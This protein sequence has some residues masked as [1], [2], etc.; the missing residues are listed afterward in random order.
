MRIDGSIHTRIYLLGMFN[1]HPESPLTLLPQNP[2]AVLSFDTVAVWLG[3]QTQLLSFLFG[4][5]FRQ[6]RTS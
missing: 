2:A 6:Q 4:G 5:S 1:I 3:N